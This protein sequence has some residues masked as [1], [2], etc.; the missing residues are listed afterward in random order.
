MGVVYELQQFNQNSAGAD[1]VMQAK[2]T[3]AKNLC[4]NKYEITTG[5]ERNQSN[6]TSNLK[7]VNFVPK[8]VRKILS[9][10]K[11]SKKYNEQ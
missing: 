3:L 6:D 4:E 2:L 11:I 7:N 1:V 9:S 10:Q 8:G 5:H